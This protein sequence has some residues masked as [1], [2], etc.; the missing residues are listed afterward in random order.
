[1]C[2]SSIINVFVSLPLYF[3]AGYSITLCLEILLFAEKNKTKQNKTKQNKT[4]TM[5]LVVVWVSPST[6]L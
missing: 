5:F 6:H 1:M 4:K 3:F 2:Y